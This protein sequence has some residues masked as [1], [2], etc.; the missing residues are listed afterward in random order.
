[1]LG[2]TLSNKNDHNDPMVKAWPPTQ[3]P[4][5]GMMSTPDGEEILMSLQ[6]YNQK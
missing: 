1:M 4:G 3:T 2:E 6:V 5:L